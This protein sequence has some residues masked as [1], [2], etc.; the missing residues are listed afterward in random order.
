MMNEAEKIDSDKIKV[1]ENSEEQRDAYLK[2]VIDKISN[3]IKRSP[4]IVYLIFNNFQYHSLFEKQQVFKK[5]VKYIYGGTE[6][7]VFK[8]N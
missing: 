7:T 1:D 2:K 4:R 5:Y 8:N 6:F 3:S